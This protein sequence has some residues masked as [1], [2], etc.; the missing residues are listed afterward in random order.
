LA[1]VGDKDEAVWSLMRNRVDYNGRGSWEPRPVQLGLSSEIVLTTMD[2]AVGN[3]G[4]CSW[5]S[6][7]K[8]R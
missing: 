5:D 4:R 8:S 1:S 6:H 3:K 2:E 7:E